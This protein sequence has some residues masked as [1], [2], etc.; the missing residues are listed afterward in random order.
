MTSDGGA[1]MSSTDHT[2]SPTHDDPPSQI[3][4]FWALAA[5]AAISFATLAAIC[6]TR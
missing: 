2:T 4:T 3:P 1:A 5:I 6:L